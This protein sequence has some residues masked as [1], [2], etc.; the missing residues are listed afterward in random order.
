MLTLQ[1][2]A[3]LVLTDSGGMQRE[4]GW[5]GTPCLILR[6]TTEWVELV[7]GSGGSMVVVGL[8]RERAHVESRRL[9]PPGAAAQIAAARARTV[10]IGD[11]HTG[12]QIAEALNRPPPPAEPEPGT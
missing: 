6:G 5:L 10:S 8:D 9:A 7:A 2:H 1:L 11:E 4:S 3:A 12:R